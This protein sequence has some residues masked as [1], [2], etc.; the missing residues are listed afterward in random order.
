MMLDWM[1]LETLHVP[2][3][4][5]DLEDPWAAPAACTPVRLRRATDGT[6]PRL[7]TSVT[8]WYDE[9]Y[10]SILFSATDDLIQAS[11]A[12]HDDPLY[13]EDVVEIFLTPDAIERYF[14]LEVNP[15]GALFD[16]LIDS[17]DGERATMQADRT[18]TCDGMF[19]VIRK[20]FESDGTMTI[21]TLVRIP[22]YSLERYTPRA[23]ETWRANFFRIDRH[24][25]QGDEYS[26]WQPTM[27]VPADFHVP[28]V[29]GTLLF[30]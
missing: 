9:N 16:A 26:A 25:Q 24:P 29:F 10:L 6:T 8:A 15:R 18:W 1:T 19:A 3:A 27:K 4:A 2:R 7:P 13:E 17:P 30:E 28:A 11:Y 20:V 14:E 12:G 22:F 5:F 21:D 23:G